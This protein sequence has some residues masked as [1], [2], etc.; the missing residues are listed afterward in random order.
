[1]PRIVVALVVLM[2]SFVTASAEES[3]DKAIWI[4]NAYDR[5][6]RTG[7]SAHWASLNI[8]STFFT[9][10]RKI[11]ESEGR[12][13]V[14]YFRWR[15]EDAYKTYG[16]GAPTVEGFEAANSVYET[17]KDPN[18]LNAAGEFLKYLLKQVTGTPDQQTKLWENYNQTF[19]S[20][21]TETDYEKR[22]ILSRLYDNAQKDPVFA[23]VFD[24]GY[25]S[26]FNAKTS[27]SA[28][29][30][31]DDNP[32][33]AANDMLHTLVTGTGTLQERVKSLQQ[34][35]NNRLKA[36]APSP[37]TP[38]PETPSPSTPPAPENGAG[39]IPDPLAQ[40]V[41]QQKAAKAA[42]Q[43]D[44][45]NRGLHSAVLVASHFIGD[46]RTAR[47]FSAV[48]NAIIDARSLGEEFNKL[49]SGPDAGNSIGF[50][51]ASFNYFAIFVSVVDAFADKGPPPEQI[52]LD[53][54]QALAKQ[55]Q[56]F[57]EENRKRFDR[58]DA[59]LGSIFTIMNSQFQDIA[60]K[61]D[62]VNFDLQTVRNSMA[63]ALLRLDQ[64]EL[65]LTNYLLLISDQPFEHAMKGCIGYTEVTG[66][67]LTKDKYDTCV[68]SILSFIDDA[69]KEALSGG[70]AIGAVPETFAPMVEPSNTPAQVNFYI[71]LAAER[72]H[73]PPFQRVPNSV[74][75]AQAASYYTALAVENDAI[76]RSTPQ[77]A[78]NDIVGEGET[79]DR[80][81]SR[82]LPLDT[83]RFALAVDSLIGDYQIRANSVEAAAAAIAQRAIGKATTW[84]TPAEYASK[85][86]QAADGF[87]HRDIP[88]AGAWPV[89]EFGSWPNIPPFIRDQVRGAGSPFHPLPSKA[90]EYIW[91]Q[92]IADPSLPAL[93]LL[94]FGRLELRYF[95]DVYAPALIGDLNI[96]ASVWGRP[97][98]T[99][100]AYLLPTGATVPD[101]PLA[102]LPYRKSTYTLTWVEQCG[103][104]VGPI[105]C[106][107]LRSYS[108]IH[109]V[110]TEQ[111]NWEADLAGESS[112]AR[113]RV[114]ASPSIVPRLEQRLDE[115]LVAQHKALLDEVTKKDSDLFRAI[116][117]LDA[118]VNALRG[119]LA[120]TLPAAIKSDDELRAALFGT[121]DTRR[122]AILEVSHRCGAPSGTRG[123][124]VPVSRRETIG[125]D[126]RPSGCGC[127][128]KRGGGKIL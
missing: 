111:F 73:Y 54:I 65:S 2:M 40:L 43:A 83:A 98:V 48:A 105:L 118:T 53:Q 58:I 102:M 68:T 70:S 87:I 94:G 126:G 97:E 35:V 79:L 37:Q 80:T 90:A 108:N 49:Y 9:G 77:K 50:A 52:I 89:L 62:D 29:T 101:K 60:N 11:N 113:H 4:G 61:L 127:E 13:T 44:F 31:L 106:R 5:I 22:G 39:Q 23:K 93:E 20:R 114:V 10:S 1:M 33:F 57:Q 28:Q 27:S 47:Q 45:E 121:Q 81:L 107:G 117:S 59:E 25:S 12:Y 71:S 109:G 19:Y 125:E 42:A 103:G 122:C 88:I 32:D 36:A 78:L 3:L 24:E 95:P 14:N 76:F 6:S 18:I 75:W 99:V 7:N 56:A 112:L 17:V 15:A 34:E 69:K 100:F 86:A 91:D 82:D 116:S 128:A 38:V 85:V 46:P 64:I 123:Q 67:R 115:L 92:M 41:E 63:Q 51:A 74:R 84:L 26:L 30:I 72:G 8:L 66:Q 96:T 119:L 104:F 21:Y 55:M 120:L 16:K 124:H 110:P